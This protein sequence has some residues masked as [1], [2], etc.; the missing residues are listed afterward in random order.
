[1]AQELPWTLVWITGASSGIGYEMALQLARQGVKVAATARSRD[2]LEALAALHTN[3]HAYPADVTDLS[4]IKAT[5][6]RIEAEMGPIDLAILNA[7]VWT[8]MS[9]RAFSAKTVADA[10]A[11]NFQGIVNALEPLLPVMIRRGAGHVALVASIAGYRGLPQAAAYAPS[12]AAVINLA[13]GLKFDLVARGISVS[14]INPGFIDTPMTTVNTFPMP[15][16]MQA[17][18]AASRIIR[19]LRRGKF[20]IAF[21]WPMVFLGKFGRMVPN[22]VYFFV[23]RLLSPMPLDG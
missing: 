17:P 19:G 16:M 20:E 4:A 18:D 13:E 1:M 3:I 9:A 5:V 10:M 22:R 6:A 2:N 7:G 8:Q 11:V 12:K 21:P 15:F 14:V 23:S